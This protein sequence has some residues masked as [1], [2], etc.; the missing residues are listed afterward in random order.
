MQLDPQNPLIGGDPFGASVIDFL[1]IA[2]FL[3]RSGNAEFCG[4]RMRNE[5]L[6]KTASSHKF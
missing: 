4:K 5:E 3:K 6:L 2:I 1:Q